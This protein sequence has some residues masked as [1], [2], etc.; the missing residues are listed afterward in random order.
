MR[1]FALAF[2]LGV[3]VLQTRP[4][5]AGWATAGMLA[6]GAALVLVGVILSSR[7]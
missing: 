2:L 1:I 3:C 5:L 4:A 6:L 7:K